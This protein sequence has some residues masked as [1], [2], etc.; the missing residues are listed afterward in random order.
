[1]RIVTRLFAGA[2]PNFYGYVDWQDQFAWRS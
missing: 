1:M 2:W